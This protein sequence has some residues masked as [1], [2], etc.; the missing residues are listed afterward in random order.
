MY[1]CVYVCM[2][3]Y[4]G[5]LASEPLCHVLKTL[6]SYVFLVGVE[7]TWYWSKLEVPGTW[8]PNTP[9]RWATSLSPRL[10]HVDALCLSLESATGMAV[11]SGVLSI[12]LRGNCSK[13]E[14]LCDPAFLSLHQVCRM[15]ESFV[16][17]YISL[18]PNFPDS[19]WFWQIIF[20][21]KSAWVGVWVCVTWN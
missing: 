2:Y 11:A 18:S 17:S 1:V 4:F 6:S 10:Y 5:F 21:L 16:I 7:P 19:E 12:G 14:F 3:V 8:L 13:T 9:G 15:T 20:V